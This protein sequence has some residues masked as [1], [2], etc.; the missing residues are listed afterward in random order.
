MYGINNNVTYF[1]SFGV[2][3]IPKDIKAFTDRS[4]STTANI[5]RIQAYDSILCGFF[6]IG[7]ITFMLARKTLFE[8]TNLSFTK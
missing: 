6:C 5:F 1:D 3:F 2:A 7:F 8:F 4:L